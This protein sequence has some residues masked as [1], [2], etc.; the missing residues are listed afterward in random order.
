MSIGLAIL[1]FALL[2]IWAVKY[3][4][5]FD[6]GR[7]SQNSNSQIP[8]NTVTGSQT[9]TQS[10]EVVEYKVETVAEN[11]TVPWSIVFTDPNR[12]LVSERTGGI[13]QVVNGTVDADPLITF[14]NTAKG[15]ELA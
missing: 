10:S 2:L 1:I 15:G 11:L 7:T 14:S 4:A 5:I 13:K 3:L 6:F 9:D 12:M 8:V